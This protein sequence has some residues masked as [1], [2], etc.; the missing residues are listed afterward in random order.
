[1]SGVIN[2]P[3][4]Y[5]VA[6]GIVCAIVM[7]FAPPTQAQLLRGGISGTAIDLQDAS[8]EGV[9]V[10]ATNVA[11][12]ETET[13][14]SNNAGLYRLS[15]YSGKYVL[16][17]TRDG[18]ET[19]KTSEIE[20]TTSKD[21]TFDAHLKVGQIATQIEVVANGTN[22]DKVG[23]TVRL[24][25]PGRVMDEIPMGTST[26]VPG[27]AR[28]FARFPL[29]APG[30][31]RVLFQNETSALGHRGREN[32]YMIDGTDNNDQSV[33]LP[34]LFIPPEAIEEMDLQAATFSAEYGRNI[35]GQINVIT[36]RGS[37]TFT[38]QLW[39]FYRGNALEPLSLGDWKALRQ[40][41]S[42]ITEADK[43]NARNPRLV[44]N[45]FGG[46]LGG[47]IIK[48]R[49]F[50]FG[51][52]QGNMLRTGPRGAGTWCARRDGAAPVRSGSTPSSGTCAR[53]G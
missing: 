12:G 23:A 19:L 25:L 9:R 29:F 11:T 16:E 48:N 36:K 27:G 53:S 39:E 18:F 4:G 24:V 30:F 50:F 14:T 49:T 33:T 45:Q 43:P 51:M 40:S 46:S 42:S 26:L 3:F 44:D 32:N 34:A 5:V 20:V 21:T 2:K 17:F 22:L 41:S 31:S 35:G 1:M 7:S 47:P 15:L 8:I 37:N 52:L 13:T 28:N 38:G 10:K 6:L